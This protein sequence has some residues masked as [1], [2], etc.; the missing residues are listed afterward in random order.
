LA[1]KHR[2]TAGRRLSPQ[3]WTD[4]RGDSDAQVGSGLLAGLAGGFS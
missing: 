4:K 3:K 1:A 2:E